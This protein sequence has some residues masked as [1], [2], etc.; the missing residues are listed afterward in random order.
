MARF[1]CTVC[2]WL[3]DEEKGD[4][5]SSIQPGTSFARIPPDWVCPVCKS[6]KKK[7]FSL[8]GKN[9]I[10]GSI[11]YFGA[12]ER[13]K[14]E[15]EPDLRSIFTKAVSGQEELSSMRTIKYRNLFEDILFIPGQLNQKPL[16]ED[17]V[18]VHLKT[19]IGPDSKRPLELDLPILVS[20]MS[21][22]ALSKEA[23]IA[24]AKGSCM[25]RTAIGSGEGGM[26]PE[27][28]KEAYKYIFEYS[29]GRFGAS[30]EVMQQ[31]D[32]IEIKIGQAAK[33][34]LGGH[35][36]ASKVTEEIAK[37]RQV[38]PFTDIVSPANH[39][40]INSKEDLKEKVEW[41]R[42]L[43]QGAPIGIKLVAGNIEK[44]LAIALFSK[45]DYITLDCRGG[46]TGTAPVHVKDNFGV[47]VP[48]ATLRARKVINNH[49]GPHPT[50]II[51]GG[52]RTSADIAKCLA[53]GADAVALGTVA[54]I[55]I[56]CQQYRM[57]HLGNCPMGIATHDPEL[58]QR[59]DINRSAQMLA[60]LFS[61]YASEL[62][63]FVRIVGKR[64]IHHLKKSHL[65]TS[66][67]EL[68][69]QLIIK[70]M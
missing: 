64:K 25:V 7:F 6:E 51:T 3:Y 39:S 35:L 10:T 55:A 43:S 29:T 31:A 54:M 59:L 28:K 41:L 23:K 13:N 24:L 2:K 46:A 63:D 5:D 9:E 42:D 20:H 12:L 16:R 57:C 22:G 18:D 62:K 27:E 4:A 11:S 68:S 26:L 48:F 50:L 60:N 44:D 69:Q 19:T 47:Y 33:A 61:V 21:F 40:D 30:E 53:L 15:I 1:Q 58:R 32:S 70:H 14:D 34:G 8:S 65:V 67:S 36:P 56:G 38:K 45:P 37:I 52:L 17:E 66:N 49:T